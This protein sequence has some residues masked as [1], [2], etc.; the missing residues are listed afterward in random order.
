MKD[1]KCDMLSALRFIYNSKIY[2]LL[3]DKEIDLYVESSAYVYEFL[4]EEYHW[5]TLRKGAEM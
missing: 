2:T 4:K 5:G 1:E 3:M